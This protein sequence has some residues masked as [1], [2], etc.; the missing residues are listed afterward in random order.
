MAFVRGAPHPFNATLVIALLF[1]TM[2][3]CAGRPSATGSASG[4]PDPLPDFHAHP[5]VAPDEIGTKGD[6]DR[7]PTAD[8]GI[9]AAAARNLVCNHLSAP[10]PAAISGRRI[11]S[12][13]PITNRIPPEIVMR[14]IATRAACLRACYQRA[15]A[16]KPNL[17][18]RVAIRLVIDEDG[19]LRRTSVWQNELGDSEVAT[20]LAQ[21]LVGLQFPQPE[22]G[23]VTVIYPLELTPEWVDAGSPDASR[24]H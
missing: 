14:P 22:G 11:R 21:E 12:G 23:K 9:H 24:L 13:P 7:T 3:G 15:L 16:A 2:P 19:W 17:Q 8:A 10:P 20:C 6:E 18:G 5:E 1:A 4:A